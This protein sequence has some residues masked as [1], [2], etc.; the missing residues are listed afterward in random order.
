MVI[1]YSQK[2]D[3]LEYL[4]YIKY[5]QSKDYLEGVVETVVLED[6][7]GVVGLKAIRVNIKYNTIQK[8]ITYDD[9]VKEIEK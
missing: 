6:L 4:R 5:L 9:L 2:K 7:Q 3:E 8:T 1:V